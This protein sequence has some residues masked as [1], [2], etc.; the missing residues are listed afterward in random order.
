[1]R[2]VNHG[3]ALLD[4]E[5]KSERR[6]DELDWAARIDLEDLVLFAQGSCVLGQ[7]HGNYD[8]GKRHLG[9]LS[10]HSAAHYGF[11]CRT[12]R[13]YRR[14]ERAWRKIIGQRQSVAV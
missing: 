2:T 11:Y 13:G 8:N 14:T 7:L 1:M 5:D 3:V 6:P 9:L 12:T 10:D 4:K